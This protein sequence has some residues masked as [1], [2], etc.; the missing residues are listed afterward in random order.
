ME[1]VKTKLA[2][3]KSKLLEAEKAAN[4]AQEELDEY[5]RKKKDLEAEVIHILTTCN[6]I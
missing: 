1:V 2:T 3:M 6:I 4:A 5:E